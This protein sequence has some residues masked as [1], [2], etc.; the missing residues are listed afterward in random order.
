MTLRSP[1]EGISGERWK[2]FTK[3]TQVRNDVVHKG[4]ASFLNAVTVKSKFVK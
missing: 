4:S 2:K 3:R 1:L